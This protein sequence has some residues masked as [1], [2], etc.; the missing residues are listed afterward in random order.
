MYWLVTEANE[1]RLAFRKRSTVYFSYSNA[2]V[3]S[4]A[5]TSNFA[6]IIKFAPSPLQ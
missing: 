5:G 1:E 6:P 3:C 2:M 4:I